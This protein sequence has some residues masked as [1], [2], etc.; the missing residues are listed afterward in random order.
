MSELHGPCI[1]CITLGPQTLPWCLST[2]SKPSL[3]HKCMLHA[4]DNF[5]QSYGETQCL[6]CVQHSAGQKVEFSSIICSCCQGW[7]PRSYVAGILP[8]L[9]KHNS[10]S[11]FAVISDLDFSHWNVCTV[12]SNFCLNWK[13]MNDIWGWAS[14]QVLIYHY[15]YL[16][17]CFCSVLCNFVTELFIYKQGGLLYLRIIGF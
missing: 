12:K 14:S 2:Y 9:K 5:C 1:V 11:A 13:F 6:K 10:E 15:S 17:W 8:T 3:M 16:Y 7:S 4:W